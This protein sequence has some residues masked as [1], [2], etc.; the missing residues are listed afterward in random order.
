VTGEAPRQPL[1]L[2]LDGPWE[3]EL[4]PTLDNRWGDFRL[5]ASEAKIGPEARVFRHMQERSPDPG[6]EAPGFDDSSWPRETCGFGPKFWKLGPLP[7]GPDAEAADARLAA[8]ES[9]D[10]SAPVEIGGKSYRWQPY[11]FS[12]RWG[13]EGDPGHQGYH[14]LKENITKKGER[15]GFINLED[16]TGS[17]EVIVF[18]ETY[19]RAA[20][21]LKSD[22]PLVVSGSI[23]IGEKSTKIKATDIV[24]LSDLTER[25]T[26]RV[27]LTLRTV[28]LERGH[29]ESLKGIIGRHRGNCRVSLR[30]QLPEQ[31]AVTINLPDA[32]SVAA[33]EDLSLEVES[34]LGYNAISFK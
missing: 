2:V 22:T 5:P 6:W 12:W 9:V 33:R 28:G 26:K 32:Y 29:L 11:A 24:P 19:A 8:M 17:V 25:E 15:M 14:G 13:V 34:L 7:E 1:P 16:L 4:K 30:F 10:P 3:F 27:C 31:C 21:H 18:P 20:D 23:D